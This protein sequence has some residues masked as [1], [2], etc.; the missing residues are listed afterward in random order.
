M[1]KRSVNSLAHTASTLVPYALYHGPTDAP[2]YK[3][4]VDKGVRVT[5]HDPD[6][7]DQLWEDAERMRESNNK[8]SHLYDNKISLL[9]T[10]S[11]IDIPLMESLK[12]FTYVLYTD[13]DVY[14]R[15][16]ILLEQFGALPESV[17]MAVEMADMFPFNAGQ[18]N[19]N[20]ES[21]CPPPP[22]P[23]PARG[24]THECTQANNSRVSRHD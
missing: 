1:V 8:H 5:M 3:W 16:P 21:T 17:A 13:N 4:L 19:V 9:S 7:I 23:P 22:P 18:C 10:F 12:E 2:I 20:A 6:W 15:G 14:F 24:D 11:R